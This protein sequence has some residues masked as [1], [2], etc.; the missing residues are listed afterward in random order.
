MVAAVTNL[1]SGRLSS[2]RLLHAEV[3]AAGAMAAAAAALSSSRDG[4]VR[5][6]N[7]KGGRSDASSR[8][9]VF[10][11]NA[12]ARASASRFQPDGQQQQQQQQGEG[13]E[14]EGAQQVRHLLRVRKAM[15][16]GGDSVLVSGVGGGGGGSGSE[17]GGLDE[18]N[19]GLED[20]TAAPAG[21]LR[22]AGAMSASQRRTSGASGDGMS[23][24]ARRRQSHDNLAASASSEDGSDADVGGMRSSRMMMGMEQRTVEA[25]PDA[26]ASAIAAA[27]STAPA[28]TATAATTGATMTAATTAAATTAV[29]ATAG[30]GLEPMPLAKAATSEGVG[31]ETSSSG[32]DGAGVASATSTAAAAALEEEFWVGND[33]EEEEEEGE[34]AETGKREG[35]GGDDAVGD[36]GPRQAEKQIGFG[37][38]DRGGGDG[39]GG[40]GGGQSSE[41]MDV[42]SVAGSLDALADGVWGFDDGDGGSAEEPS[43]KKPRVE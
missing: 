32:V 34:E 19:P 16:G 36:H 26:A 41:Q 37:V 33:G 6:Q 15:L 9:L 1:P 42:D 43:H 13:E 31:W 22:V 11:P 7:H 25:T 8:G 30:S 10:T 12:T 20:G 27:A 5:R 3:G 39:D 28:T 24:G 35:E 38:A 21:D 18:S 4:H 14:S 23:F 40:G 17:G 2:L 29:A